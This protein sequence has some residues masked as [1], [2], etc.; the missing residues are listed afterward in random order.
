MH[1]NREKK[2]FIYLFICIVL[3]LTTTACTYNFSEANEDLRLACLNEAEIVN[4]KAHP[5]RAPSRGHSAP[6]IPTGVYEAKAL[7]RQMTAEL[8]SAQNSNTQP[9]LERREV[10]AK[11]CGE[12]LEQY[13]SK[14][15]ADTEHVSVMKNICQK[16]TATQKN[17]I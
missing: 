7:C 3:A 16:M 6:K 8:Q 14:Y 12:M 17:S 1:I 15:P 5:F 13:A 2:T 10:L 11:K 9:S 4:G